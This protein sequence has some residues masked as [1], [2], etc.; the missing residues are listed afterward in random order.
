MK[1]IIAILLGINFLSIP[2]ISEIRKVYP[3][4]SNSEAATLELNSKL[5]DVTNESN[6]TLVAY[7]GASIA[8]SAKFAKKIKDKIS[9]LKE[10]SKLIEYAIVSEP[11]NIEIRL[12]RLSIQ[13]NVPKITN[14]Y[15]NKKEDA[16]FIIVHYK[17]QPIS[18]KEYLKSFILQSKSF[19]ELEKQT[20]K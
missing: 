18:L 9:D 17:E 12:I 19:T 15:K 10:G 11:K 6:K 16:I 4:A 3:N 5:S 20:L 7:K 2:E 1:W 14:Y 13:E 8:M